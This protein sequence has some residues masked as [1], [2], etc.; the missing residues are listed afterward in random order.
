MKK[1]I[2]QYLE[3]KKLAWEESTLLSEAKRL[4]AHINGIA[5]GPERYFQELS[6]KLKPYTIKTV[7]IRL[8]HFEQWAAD[9]GLL[10]FAPRFG[11][12]MRTNR[13][14]FKSVY[15]KEELDVS[16]T[17]AKRLILGIKDE[18]LKAKAL[19]LLCTGARWS[20]SFTLDAQ[21]YVVGKGRKRRKLFNATQVNWPYTYQHFIT[22]LKDETGLKPHSLRKLFATNLVDQGVK[23]ADLLKIMGWSS[24]VTASS[25]LQSKKEGELGLFIKNAIG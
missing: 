14:L 3:S 21:G 25:Y 12:F 20:E 15:H 23:E 6:Q 17:E 4:N 19:Q 10:G 2:D 16:F 24:I 5:V 11:A 9:Q 13:N 1:L 8:S 18:L 22:R 7:F